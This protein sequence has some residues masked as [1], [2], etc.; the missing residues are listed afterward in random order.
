VSPDPELNMSSRPALA[1]TTLAAALL[2]AVPAAQAQVQLNPAIAGKT[3]GTQAEARL[4]YHTSNWDQMLTADGA[5]GNPA[6]TANLS[7]SAA[8]LYNNWWDFSLSFDAKTDTLTWSVSDDAFGTRTL[9][10]VE[11]D[12]FNGLRI[13][14]RT[15][16]AAHT[17]SWK[18]LS[19]TADGLS[20]VG[21][22]NAAGSTVNKTTSQFVVGY[23]AS[24]LSLHDWRLT[25]SVM[26]TGGNNEA[27]RLSI[28]PFAVAAVPEPGTWAMLLAGLAAVGFMARRRG[29]R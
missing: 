13:D 6:N 19:F 22:L 23:G 5:F 24:A 9:S 27:T 2:L 3:T 16:N 14:M 15:S 26:A 11:S 25:G 12:A 1:L 21:A 29:A 4:K 28:S 20:N 17:L 7:N 18:D 10:V 8:V